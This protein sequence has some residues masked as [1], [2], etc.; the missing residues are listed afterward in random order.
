MTR[1]NYE[2]VLIFVLVPETPLNEN[3]D[4]SQSASVP[5]IIDCLEVCGDERKL[6]NP[7]ARQLSISLPESS[8]SSKKFINSDFRAQ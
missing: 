2:L 5:S 1:A 3:P 6:T 4:A 7:R 8:G